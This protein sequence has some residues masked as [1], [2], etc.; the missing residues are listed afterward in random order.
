MNDAKRLLLVLK[1]SLSKAQIS[2]SISNCVSIVTCKRQ[3]AYRVGSKALY[4]KKLR[5]GNGKAYGKYYGS[6]IQENMKINLENN[7]VLSK[8]R[9]FY[10]NILLFEIESNRRLIL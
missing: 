6:F 8:I 4:S 5:E 9:V 1:S 10:R 2:N 3:S 7:K